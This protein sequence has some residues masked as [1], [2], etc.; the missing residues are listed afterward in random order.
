ML[1]FLNT[2]FAPPSDFDNIVY[3]SRK[4][5]AEWESYKSGLFRN[6]A[7]Y[8]ERMEFLKEHDPEGYQKR[9]QVVYSFSRL[10]TQNE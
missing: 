6:H 1:P 2:V 3:S 7:N 8:K 4:A 10:E 5:H 9:I